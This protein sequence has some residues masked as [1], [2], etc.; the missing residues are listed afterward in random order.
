MVTLNVTFW[1]NMMDRFEDLNNKEM[2]CITHFVFLRVILRRSQV[3]LTFSRHQ[4]M[5]NV[6]Y[7]VLCAEDTYKGYFIV[8]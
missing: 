6:S 4:V 3:L 1:I 5:Y 7:N 8:H 2:S